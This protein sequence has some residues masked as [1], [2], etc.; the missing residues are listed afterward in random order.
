MHSIANHTAT[1][2]QFSQ[3]ARPLVEHLRHAHASAAGTFSRTRSFTIDPQG[4]R[5]V[6]EGKLVVWRGAE[7]TPRALVALKQHAETYSTAKQ[8]GQPTLEPSPFMADR[9]VA[10]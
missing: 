6:A 4:A 9:R 1:Q 8:A 10:A 5:L 2:K 3:T 7:T